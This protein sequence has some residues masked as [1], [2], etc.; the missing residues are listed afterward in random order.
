[1]PYLA[2]S[3]TLFIP[4]LIELILLALCTHKLITQSFTRTYTHNITHVCRK[5][6][7]F[8]LLISITHS[9]IT[10]SKTITNICNAITQC[11]LNNRGME[12]SI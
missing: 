7:P 9:S 4:E 1:M 6:E 8:N 10:S 12:G 3:K 11:N 5:T 2:Y